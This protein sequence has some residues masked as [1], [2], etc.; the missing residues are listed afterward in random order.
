M[1]QPL[2]ASRISQR[3]QAALA[4]G[5]ADYSAKRADLIRVAAIVF[6]EKG[7]ATATLNDIAALFGT[8][9][10]S[11]YYYVAS[12]EELFQEC[13]QNILNANVATAVL[14]ADLPVSPREK[15][16]KLIEVMISSQVEHFPYMY[17]YI[18]EDMRQV[19]SQDAEWATRMV[20]QTHRLERFFIDAILEGVA[21]GSFRAGLSATLTANGLFGMLL[22]THRWF[23]PGR[24]YSAQD[25]TSTFT[26]LFFDGL[27]K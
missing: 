14:I 18:Q 23:V 8:D 19:V 9:R 7:Y 24:K 6:R 11:L 20:E 27:A 13:I 21:D 15:L 2:A 4:D 12:K 26:T 16:T 17:V 10:A 5:G 1:T 3:R 22:W 25:L